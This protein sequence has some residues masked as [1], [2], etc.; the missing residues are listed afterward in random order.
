MRLLWE[1]EE[2]GCFFEAEDEAT[3]MVGE[4]RG[5]WRTAAAKLLSLVPEIS[6]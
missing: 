2:V 3:A 1:D 5:C 6:V 4:L